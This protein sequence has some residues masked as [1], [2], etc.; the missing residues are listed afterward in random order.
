MVLV[1]GVCHLLARWLAERTT[2]RHIPEDDTLQNHRCED[3]KSYG[4]MYLR[5]P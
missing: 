2:R 1:N 3:L 5:V 4:V